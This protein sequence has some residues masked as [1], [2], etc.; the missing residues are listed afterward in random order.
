MALLIFISVLVIIFYVFISNRKQAQQTVYLTRYS[1]PISLRNKLKQKHPY[2]SD[3]QVE[4]VF[5]ALKDYFYICHRAKKRMVSM[6]SQIVDIA[7]HE[8]ILFTKS[9]EIFCN[10]GIGSFLHHTPTEAMKTPTVAREGIKRAWRLSCENEN[11]NPSIPNRLPLLFAIDGL[12]NI[13]GGFKY[14][15]DCKDKSSPNSNSYC[16]ADI[17]CTSGCGGDSG[18]VSDSGSSGDCGGGGCGGD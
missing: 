14:S 2:L 12:L 8:F 10:K 13:E 5:K 1:F 6:P 17:G 11:I 15:L 18:D 7:W 16:A 3:E 4:M 9:Y